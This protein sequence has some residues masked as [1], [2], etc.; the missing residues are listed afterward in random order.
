MYQIMPATAAMYPGKNPDIPAQG[1][2]IA[3]AEIVKLIK[4]YSGDEDKILAGYNWGQGNLDKAITRY[5]SDWKNH[6]PAETKAY[7]I[8]I[9]NNT[10]GNAIVSAGTLHQ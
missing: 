2:D 4:K 7:I 6:A 9:E 1:K 3:Y 5:G 10:G 8:K